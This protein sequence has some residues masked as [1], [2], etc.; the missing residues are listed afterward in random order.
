MHVLFSFFPVILPPAERAMF[1]RTACTFLHGGG[2]ECHRLPAFPQHRLQV[3]A[4]DVSSLVCFCLFVFNDT[5]SFV[6]QLTVFVDFQGSE[7]RKHPVR[8]TGE[9]VAHV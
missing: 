5:N 8:R 6:A 3:S 9:E 1:L 7:T 4:W 2:G